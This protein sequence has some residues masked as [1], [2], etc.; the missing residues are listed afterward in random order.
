MDYVGTEG[1]LRHRSLAGSASS[2]RRLVGTVGVQRGSRSSIT[3]IGRVRSTAARSAR[4]CWR[5]RHS[6]LRA[7]VSI[8]TAVSPSG[9]SPA[10]SR[11]RH[12]S[13]GSKT[14][15]QSFF[16][17]TTVHCSF[18]AVTSA[19]SAPAGPLRRRHVLPARHAPT[20]LPG[21]LCMPVL[22]GAQR[23]KRIPMASWYGRRGCPTASRTTLS[24]FRRRSRSTCLTASIGSTP[25]RCP[26]TGG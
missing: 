3:S 2:V 11:R 20:C 23:L 6:A 9:C 17:L 1:R 4:L 15:F 22:R 26:W 19:S 25:P 13:V 18:S 12:A 21:P 5:S 10:L 14:T 7:R 16:M 8:A 24:G